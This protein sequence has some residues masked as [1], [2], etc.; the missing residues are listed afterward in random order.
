LT[1]CFLAGVR[2]HG[3]VRFRQGFECACMAWSVWLN[4][5]PRMLDKNAQPVLVPVA[6]C[7]KLVM[8][9]CC[10][11]LSCLMCLCAPCIRH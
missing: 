10:P 11:V 9:L 4:R 3:V 5:R 6:V 2:M 1:G 8:Q 7:D